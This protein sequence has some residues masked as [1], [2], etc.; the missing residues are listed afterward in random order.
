[1]KLLVGDRVGGARLGK[2]EASV[3]AKTSPYSTL[4]SHLILENLLK[5]LSLGWAGIREMPLKSRVLGPSLGSA[6]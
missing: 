3:W 6:V 5:T 4:T 2:Q 1:M